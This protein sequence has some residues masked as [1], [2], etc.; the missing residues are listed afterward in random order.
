MT[1]AATA[2]AAAAAAQVHCGQRSE[3]RVN[4][5]EGRSVRATEN[6]PAL[7]SSVVALPDHQRGLHGNKVSDD[8]DEREEFSE[9][10]P[11]TAHVVFFFPS[12]A[13]AFSQERHLSPDRRLLVLSPR[14][15]ALCFPSPRRC[16]CGSTGSVITVNTTQTPTQAGR[17]HDER[18]EKSR[19]SR[20]QSQWRRWGWGGAFN[21]C[22]VNL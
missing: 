15:I 8:D 16:V 5:A 9:I 11:Q 18:R 17:A 4:G 21:A 6:H 19:G 2:A 10:P 3:T 1:D 12:L 7:T 22:F 14:S 20:T 13:S